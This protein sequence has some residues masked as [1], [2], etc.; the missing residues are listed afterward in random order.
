MNLV[1]KPFPTFEREYPRR[2]YQIG[3]NWTFCDSYCGLTITDYDY[4]RIVDTGSTRSRI[5][6]TVPISLADDK[7][8]PGYLEMTSGD[9]E[10]Q[11]R[12]I[13]SSIADYVDLRIPLSILP[14]PGDTGKVS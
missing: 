10:G 9:A 5:I 6:F 14:T 4:T 2:I 7:L 11:V 8:V 13:R 3:C 1:L 12:P